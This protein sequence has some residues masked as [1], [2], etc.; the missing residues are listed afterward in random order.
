MIHDIIF[1]IGLSLFVVHEMDA[2]RRNE[3]KMFKFLSTLKPK[4]GY[5]VFSIL[6]LPFF[7]LIFW[8]LFSAHQGLRHDFIMFLNLF[9]IIH[10][11][12]HLAFIRHHDNEFR[13]VFSWLI[14][15]GMFLTGMVYAW[16]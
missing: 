8:G 13:S 10:F 14:I 7:V 4:I 2:V 12:I 3:W 1:Y 15:S 11:F 6:H 5:M 9:F 16:I